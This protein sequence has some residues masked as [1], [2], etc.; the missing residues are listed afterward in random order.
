MRQNTDSGPHAGVKMR[1][2]Q[3]NFVGNLTVEM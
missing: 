2:Q 1:C 3:P